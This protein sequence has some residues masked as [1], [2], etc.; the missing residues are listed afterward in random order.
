M[1]APNATITGLGSALP[2]RVVPNEY[3]EGFL[4]TTDEWIVERT[5]IS[6]RRWA[7]DGENTSDLAAAAVKRALEASGTEP[8]RVD[9]LVV[10]TCTPD[11]LIPGAASFVQAKLDMTCPSFDLNAACSGF[12]YGLSVA[13]GMVAAGNAE[14]V[15]V[16][17]AEVL[18]RRVNTS[19]RGTCILFGDGAG[20][21]I[22]APSE[23]PGI[24]ASLLA[25]DGKDAELITIPAGGVERPA[26]PEAQAAG[27]DKIHMAGRDVYKRAVVSMSAACRTLLD[28]AGVSPAD[29]DV[30]VPH[31]A[32]VR[33][34][35]SVV[36][37]LGVDP[38][39][40]V[41]DLESIGNT[42]AAS[43]PIALDRA[44][45]GGRISRGD[46]VLT[47]SFGA[48]MTWGAHLIRWTAEA[49]ASSA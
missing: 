44:W 20:A 4:D 2:E 21:A 30:L 39:S 41:V 46:L 48:G 40:A 37:R 11:R 7:A 3:F 13:E 6:E 15:A 42:S 33:I 26:T 10:A 38:S 18:S 43:I 27:E 8:E 49:P 17:G 31:Q 9:L 1:T 35:N 14:R 22:V 36:E 47:V 32:N 16:V 19:D 5:G 28:K 45:R 12:S 34:M 29:V 23:E 25:A 24:I